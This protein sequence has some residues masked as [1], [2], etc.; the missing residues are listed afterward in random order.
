MKRLWALFLVLMILSATVLA[1]CD[2]IKLPKL[3]PTEAA[4]DGDSSTGETV[5]GGEEATQAP[6]PVG[7]LSLSAFTATVGDYELSFEPVDLGVVEGGDGKGD[8]ACDYYEGKF[9]LCDKNSMKVYVYSLDGAEATLDNTYEFDKGFEKITVNHDGCVLLSQGIFAAYELL[10][11]GTFEELPFKHDLECSKLQDFA[12]ITW[13]NADPTII[14]DGV[15]QE[16]VFKNIN[17]NEKREGNLAMV[18]DCEI[19]GEDV[20]IGGTFV[21]NGEEDYRIGIF[22]YD[23][24]Q[25][26]MTAVDDSVGYSALNETSNGIISANVNTLYLHDRECNPLGKSDNL[27]TLAGFDGED[28]RTFWVKEFVLGDN[29]DVY[30]LVYASKADYSSEALLYRVTGF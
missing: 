21:E 9:Y 16:W 28:V 6:D 27:K 26:Y 25:L 29:D 5:D 19:A 12:A 23:G 7:P 14:I 10:G 1:G 13:V 17:D 24:N 18:F 4:S 15:E 3:L 11:D 20:L 22:D 2:L 8:F 30:M